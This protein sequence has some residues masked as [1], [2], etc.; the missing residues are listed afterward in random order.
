MY[1]TGFLSG[2]KYTIFRNDSLVKAIFIFLW[3]GFELNP[4]KDSPYFLILNA[5][6]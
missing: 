5:L 1:L 3:A 6:R 2:G 4:G